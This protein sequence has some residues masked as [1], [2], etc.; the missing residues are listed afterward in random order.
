MHYISTRDRSR[1]VTAAQ[2]ITDGIAPDGGLYLPA[3]IPA[4]TPEDLRRLA[5]LDYV[6]RAEELLCAYLVGEDGVWTREEVSRCVRAAYTGTFTDPAVAPVNGRLRDADANQPYVLELFHGP[7]CAFKD[8]ALQLLPHL[9]TVSAR[10]TLLGKEIVILTATSGDTGKAALEGFRDVPGTKIAVFYPSE[11]VSP[12]Q[13]LQMVTQEGGNVR[14]V[15]VRGNFDDTQNGVKAIFADPALRKAMAAKGRVFSSANSINW[16]RLA[17]Q[18]V[19]Y[20]SAYCDLSADGRITLGDPV[21]FVVPTG[22]FGNI[23][24]GYYAKQMGLP[25]R[26]LICASNRNRVLTDFLQTGRYDRTRPFYTTLSPSMDI[27]ISSNLERL[28]FLAT[29]GNAA[30]VSGWMRQL[31]EQGWYE[32]GPDWLAKL[33][34]TFTAGTCGDDETR[35]TI[36]RVWERT[37]WLSDPHTAVAL[38]V[39]DEI[40]AAENSFPTRGDAVPAVVVST[41][42]PYKFPASVLEAIEPAHPAL[43]KDEFAAAA[44]LETMAGIPCPPQL[45]TLRG[46]TP[47]F[48]DVCDAGDMAGYV[49]F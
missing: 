11:G 24:A 29:D 44:A 1:A 19:Y 23:L 7:T 16:G 10:Q 36:R 27:L 37:G 5:G 42:S 26:K 4:L 35:D 31:R 45:K 18:I 9:L 15:A 25:I 28:L 22:N 13:K 3:S 8:L 46:K 2:A 14:V 32:I 6:G 17:P 48:T 34:E 38:R 20:V 43:R 41:A 40:S 21:D 30:A 12:M 47:R 33:R 49:E 39:L